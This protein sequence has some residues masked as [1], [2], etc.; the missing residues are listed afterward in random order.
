MFNKF[1]IALIAAGFLF[2][3]C[4]KKEEQNDTTTNRSAGNAHKVTVEEIIN[5]SEYTYLKVKEADKEFWMAVPKAEFSVGEILFY[6]SSMEMKNFESKELNRTFE[7]IL[8]VDKIDKQLGT[9]SLNQPQKPV[10]TK[11]NISVAPAEDGITIA[12]LYSK[13]GSYSGKVVRIKGKVTKFNSGIMKKNWVHIQD[14]TS[15]GKNFDL[16][17]TTNDFV[18]TGETVIFEG[19]IILN[20]DFGYGYSY[21][22]LMED[23]KVLKNF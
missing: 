7:S 3:A 20:K 6:E 22:V 5:V 15:T 4:Q 23:A 18:Q 17:I 16:T 19:K 9:G 13:A 21:K 2:S 1:L 12:Q 8:F 10:L 11:E 14:G